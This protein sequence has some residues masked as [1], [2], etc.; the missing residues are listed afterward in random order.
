M[1]SVAKYNITQLDQ[2]KQKSVIRGEYKDVAQE[3]AG[4][5][6][7]NARSVGFVGGLKNSSPLRNEIYYMISGGYCYVGLS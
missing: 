2:L 6:I 4:A 3:S 1:N 7:S 5:I